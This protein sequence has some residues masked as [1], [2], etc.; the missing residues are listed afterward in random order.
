MNIVLFTPAVKTSA[1]GRMACL[2][3]RELLAQGHEVSVVRTE[4][5]VFLDKPKHDFGVE[6]I[7][8]NDSDQIVSLANQADALVYQVG[9]NYPFHR[10]CLEWLPRLPGIVC[11]H[12]FFLGHLFY[13]WS[14]E[15]RQEA[16]AI[17]RAWYGDEVARRFFS[18]P[19]S[20]AFI[21][22]TRNTS[23]MTQ[24]MCSMAHG[25][26]THSSWGIDRVLKACPGPVYVA[27]LAYD[28]PENIFKN[29]GTHSSDGGRQFRILTIGHVNPNKRVESVIRA[30]ANS[31]LL[32]QR[33]TYRLVGQ[34]R[35]ETIHEL[36]VLARNSGVNLVISG[37]VDDAALAHAVEQA[38]VISCLRW[39]SLEAASASAIE[40]MLYGK[41][42]V[43]TDTGFYRE[44]PDE[45][46]KKIDPNNEIDSLQST[47][48]QLF[49]DL[50]LRHTL[51]IQGQQWAKSTFTP[52]NYARKLIDIADSV[53]KAKPMI[54]A[55]NYFVDVM[56]RWGATTNVIN[57]E[58]TM[59]PLHLI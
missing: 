5:E 40:A 46:V 13:G 56:N 11:L 22:G 21:E 32:R 33:S 8:W 24:W 30:I 3:T 27:P 42:T 49:K 28:A 17:L 29:S 6:L 14:Q 37:E 44:L 10:G 43:V 47:L 59:A 12:D 35:P 36:S 52:E 25:V 19:D 58:S 18:Y 31:A 15:R 51:G 1:I 54:A 41:P 20:E 9:D 7:P 57:L 16:D 50:E 38:D 53:N 2:V 39:P 45:C 26:I 48:E 55:A 4:D 34:I 23:P